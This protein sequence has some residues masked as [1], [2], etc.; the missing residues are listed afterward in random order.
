MCSTLTEPWEQAALTNLGFRAQ[1]ADPAFIRLLNDPDI[2][3]TAAFE[4]LLMLFDG[5]QCHACGLDHLLCNFFVHRFRSLISFGDN[6][7][8]SA[9][10]QNPVHLAQIRW[11]VGPE[12][13][14]LH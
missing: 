14:G 7:Q 11:Q 12:E 1:G 5:E 4:N 2:R 9:W 8:P 13:M 10:L 6:E 3:V